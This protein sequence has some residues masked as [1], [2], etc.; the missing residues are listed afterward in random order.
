MQNFPTG[1]NVICRRLRQITLI[2]VCII[3]DYLRKPNPIIVLLFIHVT[4]TNKTIK[5]F[6]PICNFINISG[7]V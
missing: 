1:V 2:E 6:P 7:S 3:L 4:L 5:N